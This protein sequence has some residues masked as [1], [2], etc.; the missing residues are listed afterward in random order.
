M[1]TNGLISLG[2]VK[3]HFF[4][5]FLIIA[6]I[7]GKYIHLFLTSWVLALAHEFVH[8]LVGIRL[9][10]KYSSITLYPFG[11]CANLKEP[12]IKNPVYEIL[13]AVSGPFFNICI[14]YIV[15]YIQSFYNNQILEYAKNA[16]IAMAVINLL[17]CLPLDGGRIFRGILVLCADSL[18]AW[19]IS[20]K[21]GR[22]T[23]AVIIFVSVIMLLT[24]KFNFSYI[25]IGVFLLGGLCNQ[26]KG[27]SI[28]MLR[29][30][31][32]EKEKLSPNEDSTATVLVGYEDMPARKLFRRL[33]YN[34]YFVIDVINNDGK[35]INRLTETQ[36]LSAL[37]GQSIRIRLREIN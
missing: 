28:N 13:I 8:I 17:P 16:T 6:S 34:R 35:I 18:T 36:I 5:V 22:I 31:L 1:K 30:I 24:F 37:I 4:L 19:R 10:V 26:S 23:G 33:S 29:E 11:V 14:F 15:L 9:G 32:Y 20:L 2:K 7:S 21:V 12:V 25:L 27:L 3:V